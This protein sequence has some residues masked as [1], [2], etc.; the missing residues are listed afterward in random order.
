MIVVGLTGGIGSGKSTI[1]KIWEDLGATVIK[2]DDL[3]KQLM[4][5]DTVLIQSIKATFGS[6]AYLENGEL[7]KPFLAKEAFENGRV[8]ELNKLV[9]PA[10][11]RWFQEQKQLEEQKG[12]RVLVREAALL[13]D[14]GR[15]NDFDVIVVVSAD[16]D[17]RVKRVVNRDRMDEKEIQARMSKQLSQNKMRELADIV[18]E[19]NGDLTKLESTAKHV[20]QELLKWPR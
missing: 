17:V 9:H 11:Y 8:D 2:A 1:T 4:V 14:K 16:D 5:S 10:V 19:N 3:A 18:I 6:G 15:P 13:L 7:N 12:T 20:F